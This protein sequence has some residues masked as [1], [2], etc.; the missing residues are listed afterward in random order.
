MPSTLSNTPISAPPLTPPSPTNSPHLKKA[1]NWTVGNSTTAERRSP[2]PLREALSAAVHTMA[3]TPASAATASAAGT[4]ST[5]AA[6]VTR[7]TAGDHRPL[8]T[9]AYPRGI[10]TAAYRLDHPLRLTAAA[11]AAQITQMAT[12]TG[13]AAAVVADRAAEEA[14]TGRISTRTFPAMTGMRRGEMTG[15]AG[16]IGTIGHPDTTGIAGAGTMMIAGG[17]VGRGVGVARR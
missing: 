1:T 12:E 16:T 6:A 15:G 13:A 7:A 5:A 3:L 14:A 2:R 10:E 17:R 11:A 8:E 4:A 9:S